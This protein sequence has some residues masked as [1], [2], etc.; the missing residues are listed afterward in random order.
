ME[1]I[2]KELLIKKE[3]YGSCI[4]GEGWLETRNLGEFK[5]INP[6]NGDQ[7]ASVYKLSLIHI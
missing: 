4:G 7:I 5:S 3:N 2:L 6:T 1:D